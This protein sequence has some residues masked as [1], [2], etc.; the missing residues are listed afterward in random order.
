MQDTHTEP[1]WKSSALII[2]DMQN[3]FVS[4]KIEKEGTKANRIISN[5][6]VLLDAF[7]SKRMTIVHVVRSYNT[8]G[9]DAD[10]YRRGI[11]ERGEFVLSPGSDEVDMVSALKPPGAPALEFRILKSGMLHGLGDNEMA[12]YKPRLGAFYNTPLEGWLKYRG[13]DTCVF[14]GTFFPTCVRTSITEA[15][16]RDFR[17]IAAKDAIFGI[18]D[19]AAKEIEAI[20]VVCLS[21]EEIVRFIM[22]Y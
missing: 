12:M 4:P 9:S 19:K 2:I 15:N 18:Y 1:H 10:I 22:Q 3:A 20:G 16:E 5:I 6:K 13:V 11:I 7:R 17:T 21:A 14:A 8:D